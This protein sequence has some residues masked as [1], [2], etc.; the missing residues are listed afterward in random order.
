MNLMHVTKLIV[1]PMVLASSLALAAQEPD[2]ISDT[3]DVSA[4]EVL[5]QLGDMIQSGDLSQFQEM[6]TSNEFAPD[7][8]LTQGNASPPTRGLAQDSS[9]SDRSRRS[10]SPNRFRNYDR[11]QND[12]RRS[13]GRRSYRSRSE[14]VNRF[15]PANDDYRPSD[16]TQTNAPAGTETGPAGLGYAAFR[17]I[18][19]RN[20]FD[21]NRYAR[22]VDSGPRRPTTVIDS[23]T[24]V[25]TM[26]YEKGTFAFFDGTSSDYRKAL[27]L[28]DLIVGYKV[29]KIAPNSV[30]L[31]AGTNQVDLGVGM[32][33]RREDHGPWRVSNQPASYAATSGP[34]STNGVA[35]ATSTGSQA[36]ASGDQSDIIKRLMQRREQQ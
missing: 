16:R 21:P 20:I 28:N 30:T 31:V 35:S 24:L 32:Q 27:K 22:H 4:A 14:S 19:D 8:A 29:T 33:L 7:N 18:V 2:A 26:S 12:D 3:N 15:R 1:W 6:A 10:D 25:G 13:R 9:R 17:I 34:T 23:L 36:A 11:S 5:S